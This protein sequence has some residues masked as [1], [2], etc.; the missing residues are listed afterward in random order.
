[1]TDVVDTEVDRRLRG[2]VD[3]FG[4]R[5]AELAD[6][7]LGVLSERGYARTSLREIA[8]ATDFSHGVLHYYFA[9]K[10]ELITACVRR[11]KAGCV[12]RYDEIVA[13]AE[14]ADELRAEFGVAMAATL[15]QDATLHRLWYDLRTQSL[16]D[17]AYRPDVV[18]I[19]QS[20]E[21]MI[22]RIVAR[23]GE[24][25]GTAPTVTEPLAYALFDGLFQQALLAHLAGDTG[26]GD[27]L[28]TQVVAA[29]DTL[30][31]RR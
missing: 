28:D 27:R 2:R 9:D 17:P 8:K 14:T 12:T 7:A 16:F 31:P 1:M 24:L 4:E 15:R 11:Y 21:R 10:V 26:A 30:V 22:W 5:R 20:L 29:L 25:A 19:D 23:C 18:E 3:K 13:T 6:A